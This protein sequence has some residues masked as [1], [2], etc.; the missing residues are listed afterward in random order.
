M[1]KKKI[2]FHSNYSKAFTGFGKN[3]KNVLK[4]LYSTG[5]Y[6][7]VE[8]S[9]GFHWSDSKFQNMPWKTIGS[10]PDDKKLLQEINSDSSRQRAAGYGAEMIDKVIEQEKPDIYIGSEDIWAFNG[11]YSRKWWNKINCMIW[12]TLDSLPILPDAVSA[13][14]KIKN[15]YVWSSFAEK[16]LN[17]LG[18]NH[19]KTLHGL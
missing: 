14:S 19:V 6:E 15:Y 1:T 12:T 10:L 8:F 16:A 18:H 17:E 9:N 4:H 3:T 5:K 2:L 7:I 11:Y 13:A